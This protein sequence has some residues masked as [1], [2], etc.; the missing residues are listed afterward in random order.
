MK[1]LTWLVALAFAAS[2]LA[3]QSKAPIACPP[4]GTDPYALS[5]VES[6]FKS[7]SQ[8]GAWGSQ[9]HQFNNNFPALPQLGDSV[10]IAA[11]KLYG[12]DGL[13]GPKATR[14]YLTLVLFSFSDRNKVLDKTDREPRI[15]SMVLDCLRDRG[16]ADTH[17]EQTIDY[18]KSCTKD[19][20]CTFENESRFL[21]H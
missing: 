14:A 6:A 20:S 12:L 13:T 3:G 1:N 8:P 9:I 7:F 5:F 4:A 18:L 2:L 16:L 11:L 10:S 17:T 15:T 21:E 19:F